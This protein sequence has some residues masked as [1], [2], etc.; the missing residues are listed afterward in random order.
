MVI[1]LLRLHNHALDSAEPK[2]YK[3]ESASAEQEVAEVKKVL[4]AY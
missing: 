2:H 3:Q 4:L 1:S